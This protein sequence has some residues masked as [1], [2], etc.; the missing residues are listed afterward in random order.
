MEIK[1]RL[2]PAKKW[3]MWMGGVA[4]ATLI[5]LGV[6][7]AFMGPD[8]EKSGVAKVNVVK[9]PAKKATV[10]GTPKTEAY[11][12]KV[13]Q[14]DALLAEQATKQG[15]SVVPTVLGDKVRPNVKKVEPEKPKPVPET[16]R[17]PKK[18]KYEPANSRRSRPKASDDLKKYKAALRKDIAWV[19]KSTKVY[20]PHAT[21]T[22]IQPDKNIDGNTSQTEN[23]TK[24]A[25]TANELP[26]LPFES[27]DILYSANVIA[28]NSDVPSPVVAEIAS[29]AYKNT[30]FFGNFKRHE[31][32]MLLR[33]DRLKTPN[34]DEYSIDAIALDMDTGSA[35]VRSSV[36][37]HYL[38]RWGG[39]IAASFLEGFGE[40]TARSGQSFR[41]TDT[42]QTFTYP[43]YKFDDQAWIAA[44]KVGSRLAN[45][46]EKNFDR[47]PTVYAD[48]DEM[49]GI[50][51]LSTKR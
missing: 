25:V 50:M 23:T 33:F 24:A 40:A 47:P 44:G 45:I 29:G 43:E 1:K 15:K 5:V 30:T 49:F 38:E 16:K 11:N 31:K 51:I 42:S 32:Y 19:L 18:K 41:E 21:I 27:G 48:R 7:I 37:S 2:R 39:L 12:E 46:M 14:K 10:G 26:P 28:L 22:F 17:P 35:A 13:K 8:E 6:S 9:P 20:E 4:A 3:M 36:D 34:G